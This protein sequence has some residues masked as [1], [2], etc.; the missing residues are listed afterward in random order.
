MIG[1]LRKIACH[2]YP[3]VG[4]ER[5]AARFGRGPVVGTYSYDK[6]IAGKRRAEARESEKMR[7]EAKVIKPKR[8]KLKHIREVKS[9]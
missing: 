3:D 6:A 8:A 1:W 9:A 4:L 2:L 5:E 7:A